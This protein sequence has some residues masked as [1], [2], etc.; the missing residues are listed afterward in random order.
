MLNGTQ[1]IEQNAAL[2]E[3]EK[4]RKKQVASRCRSDVKDL[5]MLIYMNSFAIKTVEA[6]H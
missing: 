4:E 6:F 2:N 5:K 3:R 1:V